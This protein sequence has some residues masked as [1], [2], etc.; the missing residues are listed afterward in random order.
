MEEEVKGKGTEIGTHGEC[1]GVI[2]RPA[3][4]RCNKGEGEW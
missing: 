4:L 1:Q 2:R 3:R